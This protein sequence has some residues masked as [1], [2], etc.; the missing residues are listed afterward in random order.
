MEA[1]FLL[2]PLSVLALLVAA[3]LFVRMNTNGQFDEGNG[4]AWSVLMDDDSPLKED[5]EHP[6]HK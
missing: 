6:N 3:G 1:L 2:V 5:I 4:P